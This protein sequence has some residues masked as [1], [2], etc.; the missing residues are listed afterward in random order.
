MLD[1]DPYKRPDVNAI[2][3]TDKIRKI[4][5]RRQML[6]PFIKIVSSPWPRLASA[7]IF[8]ISDSLIAEAGIEKCMEL[9]VYVPDIYL[10][11]A[12]V[13]YGCLEIDTKT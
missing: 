10:Q 3:A 6:R 9:N 12:H 1:P 13:N 2:L 7:G 11:F 4:L 8:M 5:A